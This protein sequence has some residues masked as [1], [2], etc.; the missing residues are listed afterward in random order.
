MN[1]IK[2]LIGKLTEP[3][4]LF[5]YTDGTYY[6]EGSEKDYQEYD[7]PDDMYLYYEVYQNF[8]GIWRKSKNRLVFTGRGR[9]RIV[10]ECLKLETW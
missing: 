10:K 4:I 5:R 3:S 1:W 9:T 7:N 8:M 6:I 2:F